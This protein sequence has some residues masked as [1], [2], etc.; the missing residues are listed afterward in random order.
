MSNNSM[1]Y[2]PQQILSHNCL[3]NFVVGN[4]GGGKTMSFKMWAVK[5][6]LKTGKQF[7]YVRR[8]KSELKKN[9]LQKF[10]DALKNAGYFQDVEFKTKGHTF[11]INGKVCGYA[12]ALSTALTIKSEEFPHVNKICFD[13]FV[14]DKGHLRYLSNEVTSFLEMYESIA[15]SRDDV[16]VMFLSNAVS[17]VNPYFTFWNMKPNPSKRFSKYGNLIVEFYK[18]DEYV[19]MKKET[20]FGQIIDGTKYGDY[21]IEN[22]FLKDNDNFIEKRDNKARFQFSIVFNGVEYGFWYNAQKGLMYACM[23]LD[24]SNPYTYCLTNEDHAVN[25]ILVKSSNKSPY[26]KQMRLAYE[27]GQMRFSDMTVKSIVQDIMIT[28]SR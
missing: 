14:I 27:V 7:V 4:R 28:L 1:W 5:D 19:K 2:S 8:Y 17:V 24:P 10:F 11:Y 23:E 26:L 6:F 12:V 3:F 9:M 21:A 18:N 20:R 15:R 25:M 16:R 22:K 13:E